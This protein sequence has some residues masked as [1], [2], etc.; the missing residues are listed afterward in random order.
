MAFTVGS[1][2]VYT[3]S[4]TELHGQTMTVIAAK[5]CWCL[6]CNGSFRYQLVAQV[7][8]DPQESAVIRTL[9]HVRPRSI[10]AA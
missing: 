10:R 7:G 2:V 5:P 3:G 1:A 8:S 9:S 6:G 4:V